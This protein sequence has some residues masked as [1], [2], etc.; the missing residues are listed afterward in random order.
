MSVSIDGTVNV[1]TLPLK[2]EA[3]E[4]NDDSNKEVFNNSM[5]LIRNFVALKSKIGG[6]EENFV[7]LEA[8]ER[9]PDF[10]LF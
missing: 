1:Q 2:Q 7:Q 10:L 4:S 9:K 3:N 5:D 8:I 6:S